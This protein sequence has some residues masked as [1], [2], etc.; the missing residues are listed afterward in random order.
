M[1]EREIRKQIVDVV[2]AEYRTGMVNMFEGNVSA[3]LGDR[4]FITP[5][6]V[7]KENMTEDMVIEIDAE[8]KVV[9]ALP[10]YKPSS[11]VGMHLEVYKLRKDVKAVV[12]NH[13]LYA[14]AFAVNSMP[15]ET[16]MI[17]EANLTFGIVPVV[18]YGTPG[19]DR[20]YKEFDKYLGNTHGV[21]LANHGL[22]TYGKTLELAFSYAE[23]IEKIAQTLYVA[24]QLGQGS[25]IPQEEVK[26][27]RDFG[28]MM[29]DKEIEAAL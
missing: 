28:S 11:E 2:K 17:T 29:R 19:T 27:L 26:G 24:R 25:P 3:R 6:Q 7:A 13:S 18:P 10:G 12:H 20:I 9:N 4:F 8:G 15:I 14:T 5:S 22:L 16:D 21:L 23:G 1:D